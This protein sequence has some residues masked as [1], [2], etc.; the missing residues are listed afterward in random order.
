MTGDHCV[1]AEQPYFTALLEYPVGPITINKDQKFHYYEEL[2]DLE[3]KRGR[4]SDIPEQSFIL[5]LGF[6][7]PVLYDKCYAR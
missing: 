7:L 5:P 2:I 3:M 1:P 6:Q 4:I